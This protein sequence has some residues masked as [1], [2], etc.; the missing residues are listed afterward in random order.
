MAPGRMAL[1]VMPIAP[2]SKATALVKP[3]RACLKTMYGLTA[4]LFACLP[5]TE[6]M[7]M[8][9]PPRPAGTMCCSARRVAQNAEF[10]IQSH[11]PVHASSA[12]S[13]TRPKPVDPPALLTRMSI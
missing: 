8:M 1:L 9:R 7:L 13:C 5:S 4:A 6:E 3:F 11:P 2:Y 12:S 10:R